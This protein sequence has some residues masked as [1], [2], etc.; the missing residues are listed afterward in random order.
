[1]P[2]GWKVVCCNR[3]TGAFKISV[4][5]GHSI[6]IAEV[7]SV[8]SLRRWIWED[9]WGHGCQ[10]MEEKMAL[11]SGVNRSTEGG[12][13][14]HCLC[15]TAVFLSPCAPNGHRGSACCAASGQM[16]GWAPAPFR[17]GDTKAVGSGVDPSTCPIVSVQEN[18][19]RRVLVTRWL[20]QPSFC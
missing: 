9:S 3:P 8:S 10:H 1:M 19:R 20:N 17:T 13:T 18:L 16:E 2:L 11:V 7:I 12:R 14:A 5:V 4:W 15:C 6:N